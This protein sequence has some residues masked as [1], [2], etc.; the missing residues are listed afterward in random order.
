MKTI[1]RQTWGNRSLPRITGQ[2]T[3]TKVELPGRK[4]KK[5]NKKSESEITK[6]GNDKYG[7]NENF[8]KKYVKVDYFVSLFL[9]ELER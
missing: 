3:F 4:K 9:C 8:S 7:E 6:N 1:K 5:Q 2:L